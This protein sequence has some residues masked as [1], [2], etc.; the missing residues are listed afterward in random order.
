[1]Y[2][3]VFVLYE[4]FLKNQFIILLYKLNKDEYVYV[5]FVNIYVF[6]F[7]LIIILVINLC[8]NNNFESESIYFLKVNIFY[9]KIFISYF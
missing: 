2:M 9:F 8:F 3:I 5:E 7:Y 1:M 4:F 6:I